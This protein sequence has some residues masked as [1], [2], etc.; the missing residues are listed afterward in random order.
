MSGRPA[1]YAHLPHHDG[2]P[3]YSSPDDPGLGG[4][5]T[6]RVRVPDVAST[7]RVRVRTVPDAEPE[8]VEATIDADRTDA[9]PAATWWTADIVAR[10]PDVGYRFLLTGGSGGYRWLHEAGVTAHD[11]GD[12]SDFRRIVGSPT[13]EWPTDTVGYQ[14]FLD[15]FAASG[16]R[17]E[18]PDWAIAADWDDEVLSEPGVGVRQIYG[19]DLPGI[20]K[21]LDHLERLGVDLVYLTPFFPARSNHRYDASSF[22]AVDPLLGGDEA[23]ASLAAACRARGIRIIGDI[24][25]NHTGDRHDW[26]AAARRDAASAEADFYFFD[27]HPDGYRAWHGVPSLPKLDHSSDELARRLH[28]GPDS[29]VSR[30]LREPVALDGWRVDC[31]NTTGR[32]GADDHHARVGAATRATIES[33]A[34]DGWLVA[35]HCYDARS[36]LRS[37]GWHGAMAYQW[38]SRPLWSWLRGDAPV[39]LMTTLEM[40]RFGAATMVDAMRQLGA[41][42]PWPARQASMTMLDSHDSPR[43]RTAV[44]GDRHRHLTGLAALLTMPGVPTLFAGSEVGVEGD[45]MDTCRVPFPWDEA[46]WDRETFEAT[47]QLISVRR[48][49]P[50][51]RHGSMRWLDATDDTVTYVREHEAERVVVHLDRRGETRHGDPVSIDLRSA[52]VIGSIAT[53]LGSADID[54]HTATFGPAPATLLAIT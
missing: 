10:N 40:P 47:Q 22:D 11:V 48:A 19:G 3:T 42:L 7:E 13:P 52:G 20:E 6:V 36:D 18:L 23:L 4:T 43:F 12:D 39:A 54:D 24:T 37:G 14:V 17:R 45:S 49:H 34:P 8:I 25:L 16:E 2:S 35:E 26:F 33:L 27:E 31:A 44:G 28:D 41:G 50:A 38:F 29:V 1:A 9:D 5:F 15:R 32:S 53:I 46:D 30:Y 51:L 21:R